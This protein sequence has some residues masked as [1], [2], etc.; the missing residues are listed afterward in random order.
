MTV[1][2]TA[3]ITDPQGL[4]ARPAAQ[5]VQAAGRFGSTIEVEAN[6]Q[7]G[8]AKSIM[9]LLKLGL[10]MGDSVTI[11]ATGEDADLAASTLA[12]LLSGGTSEDQ[13]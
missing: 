11:R 8:N 13:G 6:G 1:E 4:H 7:K 3:R 10:R 5:F 12:A 2:T 9:G